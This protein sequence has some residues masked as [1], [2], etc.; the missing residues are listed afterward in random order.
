MKKILIA[1]MLIVVVIVPIFAEDVDTKIGS[2]TVTKV[3]PLKDEYAFTKNPL[4]SDVYDITA[5]DTF[6][7]DKKALSD[8]EPNVI[9]ASYVTNSAS[10]HNLKVTVNQL[11]HT[12]DTGV[13]IP[14]YAKI[15]TTA[16]KDV[17]DL[18]TD[19]KILELA[20]DETITN[21]TG[22][23]QNS[24]AFALFIDSEDFSKARVGNYE[25]TITL[26]VSSN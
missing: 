21:S 20:N 25:A 10:V 17:A 16:S 6:E 2:I 11:K 12:T 8:G 19:G 23:R 18:V 5:A 1:L 15:G 14:M 3:V 7:N 13:V 9:Y 22:L 26:T 4:E 24:K